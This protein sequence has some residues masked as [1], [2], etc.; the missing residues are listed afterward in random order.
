MSGVSAT[1]VDVRN[2]TTDKGTLAVILPHAGSSW[3]LKLSGSNAV[4]EK[5]K[6]GFIKFAESIRFP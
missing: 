3:F 2:A 5:E 6:Q 1:I 4:V